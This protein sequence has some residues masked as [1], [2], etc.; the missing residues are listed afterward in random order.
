MGEIENVVVPL[1]DKSIQ[2]KI[3]VMVQE[4]FLLKAESERLLNVAKRAVEIAIEQ[5]ENAGINY[6]KANS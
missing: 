4:S 2:E 6:I 1:V 5:D 3:T